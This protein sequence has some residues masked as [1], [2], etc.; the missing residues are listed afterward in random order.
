MRGFLAIVLVA[1]I[2]GCASRPVVNAPATVVLVGDSILVGAASEV[3]TALK[4]EGWTVHI[5][6]VGGTAI[7]GTPPIVRWPQRLDALV[8]ERR[9]DV[10][11]IELGTNDCGCPRTA[12]GIDAL[13][14]RLRSVDRVY[15][16]NVREGAPT[17]EDPVAMNDAID[18]A[19]DRWSNL[20][21]IDMNQRFD[22]RSDWVEDDRIHPNERGNKE[23]ADLIADSLPAVKAG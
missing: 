3:T 12:D 2:S 4:R 11:V 5:D 1:A 6:A 18:N 17:P 14:G 23:L 16:V 21:I 9:P 15:W 7:M 10:V 22:D 20:H 13:M 8:R 19:Q